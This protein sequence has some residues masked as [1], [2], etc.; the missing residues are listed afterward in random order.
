MD[1]DNLGICGSLGCD[2]KSEYT[3]GRIHCGHK[4]YQTKGGENC[5]KILKYFT[6]I[7]TKQNFMCNNKYALEISKERGYFII[8]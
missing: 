4:L 7:N 3:I 8:K 2:W 1:L 5:Y 6:I